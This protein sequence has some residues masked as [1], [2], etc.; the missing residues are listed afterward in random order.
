MFEGRPFCLCSILN[1]RSTRCCILKVHCWLKLN[2]HL[3]KIVHFSKG[4]WHY[5]QIEQDTWAAHY[6]Q[7]IPVCVCVCV[8]PL[9]MLRWWPWTSSWTGVATVAWTREACVSEQPCMLPWSRASCV[10]QPCACS[11][12]C[13][14]LCVC[15]CVCMCWQQLFLHQL[16]D[17]PVVVYGCR[18]ERFGGCGSV[19]D[20]SSADLPQTGSTFKV[21]VCLWCLFMFA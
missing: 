5:V 16:S 2:L 11:V 19:L 3:K 14:D 21:C 8:R 9:V 4:V 18:N 1:F 17:I 10:L 12:S 6:I 20:V 13:I 15:V 7:Y